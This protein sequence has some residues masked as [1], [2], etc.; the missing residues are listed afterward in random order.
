MTTLTNEQL[1]KFNRL[2]IIPGPEETHETFAKRADYCLKLKEQLGH[3]FT[4]TLAA[5][6]SD[7]KEVIVSAVDELIPLYDIAPDWI[8]IFFSNYK[9]PFW[10][11]GCAWIFQIAEDTPTAALIQLRRSFRHSARYLG[12]YDRHELLVH[13]LVHVGRMSFQESQFEEMLAYRTSQSAF[14]RW[15]GPI[16]QSSIESVLFVLILGIIVIFDIFLIALNRFDAYLIALWLKLIPI[17]LVAY[18]WVRLWR[19]H[20]CFNHCLEISWRA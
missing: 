13:E 9:L 15:F 11:G 18:A 4:K 6:P 5:E 19:R 10:H 7:D 17:G 12:I 1:L 2:G 14:R 16:I 3:E 8:P 20:K